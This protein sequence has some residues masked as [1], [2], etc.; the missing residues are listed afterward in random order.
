MDEIEGLARGIPC[1]FSIIFVKLCVLQ[2]REPHHLWQSCTQ[3]LNNFVVKVCD[4]FTKKKNNC[5]GTLQG[6]YVLDQDDLSSL[7]G[8][9]LS[10]LPLQALFTDYISKSFVVFLT[11]ISSF[12]SHR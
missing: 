6:D 8:G 2:L 5:P 10:C 11:S 9:F 4:F 1:C 3:D 12:M 7:D